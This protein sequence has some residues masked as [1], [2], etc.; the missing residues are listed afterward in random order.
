MITHES[1]AE[2]KQHA[3]ERFKDSDDKILV[4]PGVMTGYDFAHDL[5]RWQIL[6]KIPFPDNRDQ[7]N[8]AKKRRE[9]DPEYDTYSV[10]QQCFQAF[11]RL[12]RA[13]DDWGVT[14]IL[15]DHASYFFGK[16]NAHLMP[17]GVKVLKT[18]TIPDGGEFRR[19]WEG[20]IAA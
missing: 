5:A 2:S 12:T 18:A 6:S 20:K 8:L 11:G 17:K 9:E 14:L 15:D 4:S 16:K 7:K 19:R 3:V 1:T 13:E 10:M